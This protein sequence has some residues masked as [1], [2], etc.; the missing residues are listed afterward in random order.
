VG[1]AQLVHESL[2]QLGTAV[3]EQLGMHPQL[4]DAVAVG[5]APVAVATMTGR[6]WMPASTMRITGHPGESPQNRLQSAI[7][8]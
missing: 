7:T 2:D 5:D 1:L 4:A 8:N 6:V 3:A